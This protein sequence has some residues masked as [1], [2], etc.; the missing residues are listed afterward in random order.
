MDP[1]KEMS[2]N[3]NGMSTKAT[4]PVR[5]PHSFLG[6]NSALVNLDNLIKPASSANTM[7][8]TT[9]VGGGGVGGSMGAFGTAN[10][11]SDRPNFFAP[12]PVSDSRSLLG[13]V[14]M[15]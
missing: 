1:L 11:F 2:H 10:P 8:A 15:I 12:Q 6:E 5:T 13:L 14:I 4:P 7:S 9:A 3:N